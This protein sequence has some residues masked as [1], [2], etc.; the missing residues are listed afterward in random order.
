M[1]PQTLAL[2]L[3][4][5]AGWLSFNSVVIIGYFLLTRREALGLTQP[6]GGAW[7]KWHR[8]KRQALPRS[9]PSVGHSQDLD[10]EE[11]PIEQVVAPEIAQV[12]AAPTEEDLGSHALFVIFETPSAGI[13]QQLYALLK[14]W[15]GHF[16]EAHRLYVISGA[17][18]QNP[19]KIAHAYP[20]GEMPGPEAFTDDAS[21]LSG[22]SLMVKRPKR[23]RGFDKVQLAKL[24]ELSQAIAAFGGSVL[25][26]QRKPVTRKALKAITG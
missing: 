17:T 19:I 11:P 2:T 21:F 20:P 7:L 10:R 14:A 25:D 16:D 9:V 5:G 23:K 15:E 13:N 6:Q 8:Q 24:V 18:P 1:T 22:V 26:E 4:I 12:V 3:A